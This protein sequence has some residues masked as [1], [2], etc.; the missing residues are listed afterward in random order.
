MKASDIMTREVVTVNSMTTVREIADIL[1]E[2]HISGLPVVEQGRVVGIVSEKDIIFRDASLHLPAFIQIL[3]GIIFLGSL[4]NYEQSIRKMTGMRAAEIMSDE[5]ISVGP[6]ASIREIA[7]LM[8]ENEINRVP[9]VADG[10]LVGIVTR[11]DIIKHAA[12]HS[13]IS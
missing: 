3:D 11:A 4:K 2:R 6:D 7:D 5:V 12:G 10:V 8:V 13:V 1:N 9:I